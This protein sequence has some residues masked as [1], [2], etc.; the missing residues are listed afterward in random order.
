MFHTQGDVGLSCTNNSVE[1][2]SDRFNLTRS[3]Y[4]CA[5]VDGI[6]H[7]LRKVWR[8]PLWERLPHHFFKNRGLLTVAEAL[9]T[10]VKSEWTK[11]GKIA[12]TLC[13]FPCQAKR[14]FLTSYSLMSGAPIVVSETIPVP[15]ILNLARGRVFLLRSWSLILFS[16][17]NEVAQSGGWTNTEGTCQYYTGVVYS[18]TDKKGLLDK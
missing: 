18:S 4:C 3:R 9:P 13:K 7:P 8:R 17:L 2:W 16:V 11:T 12:P 6:A 10:R 5:W 1:T 14:T 15:S